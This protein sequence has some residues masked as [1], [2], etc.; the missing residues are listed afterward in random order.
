MQVKTLSRTDLKQ[1]ESLSTILFNLVL[2][3]SIRNVNLKR[4]ELIYYLF[5]KKLEYLQ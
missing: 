4:I 2:K 3:K 5:T 1:G